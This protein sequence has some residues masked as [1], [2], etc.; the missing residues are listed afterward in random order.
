MIIKIV[1]LRNKYHSLEPIEPR[2]EKTSLS[3]FPTRSDTNWAVQQQKEIWNQG[4]IQK[5]LY[6]ICS[7]NKGADQLC[8]YREADL[9]ICFR[10]YAKS[11]SAHDAVQNSTVSCGLWP[12]N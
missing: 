9:R 6:Y 8:G 4:I 7:E 5:G 3:G 11:R 12:T 1:C 10:V 2:R